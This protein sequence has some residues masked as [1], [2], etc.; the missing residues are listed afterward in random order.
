MV[1]EYFGGDIIAYP[2]PLNDKKC[3]Y[4]NRINGLDI[5]LTFE[6]FKL[7]LTVTLSRRRKEILENTNYIARNQSTY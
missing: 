2:N 7:Q 6:Q 5:D 3:H 4:F 1:Q